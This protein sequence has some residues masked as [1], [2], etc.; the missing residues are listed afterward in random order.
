M[1]W[2]NRARLYGGMLLVLLLV[3][4]LVL[5]FNQRRSQALS[6]TGTVVTAEARIGAS[7]GGVVVDQRARVGDTVREGQPLVTVAVPQLGERSWTSGQTAPSSTAAY[8]VDAKAGTVTYRA[9]AS[10]VVLD[11]AVTEGSYVQDGA[12]LGRISA[13]GS[14][15][16]VADFVLSPRDY[17]RIEPGAKVSLRLPDDSTVPGTVR[18]VSVT[19][20][21]SLAKTRVTIASAGLRDPALARLTVPGTPL[22]ATLSLRDDGPLA[23]PSDIVVDLLHKVGIA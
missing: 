13:T 4:A 2:A 20:D 18:T 12:E 10:G 9:L 6:V 22:A 19:T 11:V 5:V 16:A 21:A 3:A 8:T 7:Y 14:Q 23:G 15:E 1:T 17:D